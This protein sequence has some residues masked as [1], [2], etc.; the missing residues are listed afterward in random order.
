MVSTLLEGGPDGLRQIHL[1]L[2]TWLDERGYRDLDE[3]RGA[4]ALDNVA[5][6]HEF[7]RLNYAHLLQSWQP[8][9]HGRTP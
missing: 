3:A 9:T 7:E 5:N 6:P 2:S 8:R 1:E 4:T